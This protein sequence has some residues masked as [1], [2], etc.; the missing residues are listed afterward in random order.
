VSKE[1]EQFGEL[2]ESSP[3]IAIL[4]IDNGFEEITSFLKDF[5]SQNNGELTYKKIS[6]I[7][8]RRFRLKDRNFEYAVISNCMASI[9]NQEQFIKAVYHSLENSAFI[10]LLEKKEN[11]DISRM[12]ELLDKC[13]FRA[14][15]SIDIFQSYNLVMAK[16]LH[17]WG[18][19]Q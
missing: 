10:I 11:S 5:I 15:N 3:N 6:E 1:F 16:K 19:G 13:N 4:N 8:T 7:D 14:V 17:M 9:E 12:C 18:A 2:L